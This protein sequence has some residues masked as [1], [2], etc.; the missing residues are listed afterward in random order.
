MRLLFTAEF[1]GNLNLKLE[2]R[3]HRC[4]AQLTQACPRTLSRLFSVWSPGGTLYE[5]LSE[6]QLVMYGGKWNARKRMQLCIRERNANCIVNMIGELFDRICYSWIVR[7]LVSILEVID[8]QGE[9]LAG[10]RYP[11]HTDNSHL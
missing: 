7:P 6:S 1:S 3:A 9:S 8:S 4:R 2:Y 10:H 5:Q 11:L